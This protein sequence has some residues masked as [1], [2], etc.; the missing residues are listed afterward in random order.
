[1]KGATGE[2]ALAA[3]VSQRVIGSVLG[4]QTSVGRAAM[5][6]GMEVGTDAAIEQ[7][8]NHVY[9]TGKGWFQGDLSEE[10][11]RAAQ[12]KGFS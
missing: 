5:S 1:M 3:N 12:E 6:A 8:A 2:S 9:D 4:G 10:D 11:R 7:G